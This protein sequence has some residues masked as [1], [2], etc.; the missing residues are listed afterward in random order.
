MLQ[1][2][3]SSLTSELRIGYIDD[4]TVGGTLTSVEHDDNAIR[5]NGPSVGLYLNVTKCELIT[6]TT[7]AQ[8][9]FLSEFFV[10]KL[11]NMCL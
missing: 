3:L 10:V 2:I 6:T 4:I 9:S 1:P 8:T 7:P 11:S 5:N